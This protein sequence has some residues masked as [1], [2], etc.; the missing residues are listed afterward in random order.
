MRNNFEVRGL[1]RV[2]G[3]SHNAT[4]LLYFTTNIEGFL[5]DGTKNHRRG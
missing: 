2:D 3:H 4:T 1:K 5:S